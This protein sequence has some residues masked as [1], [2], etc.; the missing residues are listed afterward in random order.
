VSRI[1]CKIGAPR[2]AIRRARMNLPA[3]NSAQML[4]LVVPTAPYND[5]IDAMFPQLLKEYQ[6]IL[7][8]F[9]KKVSRRIWCEW[10]GLRQGRFVILLLAALAAGSLAMPTTPVVAQ[11]FE[12]AVLDGAQIWRRGACGD[13]HGKWADGLGDPNFPAG[14]NLRETEL[15]WDEI[16]ETVS[17]GRPGTAMPFHMAGAYAEISC[18]EIPVGEVLAAEGKAFEREQLENL[19][20][21]LAEAVKGAGEVTLNDC[22]IYYNGNVDS[23]S[24]NRYR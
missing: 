22:I 20:T 12:Q 13:C 16:L 19:A 7:R 2:P 5:T 8:L 21:Y 4:K 3:L 24:C 1:Q 17:C 23:R 14:P 11:E 18:Y 6:M 10:N 15:T 9:A